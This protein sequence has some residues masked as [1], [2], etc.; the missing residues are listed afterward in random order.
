MDR[1]W[2]PPPGSDSGTRGWSFPSM[3]GHWVQQEKP[4]AVN[5]LLLS[6]LA[7]T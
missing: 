4:D 2:C 7:S 3:E 5:E 1:A 6:F